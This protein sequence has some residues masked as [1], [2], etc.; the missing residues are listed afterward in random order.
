MNLSRFVR[1]YV[2]RHWRWYTAGV[3]SLIATNWASVHI[4]M[5]V[6]AAI[7]ALSRTDAHEIVVEKAIRIG[8][9]GVVVIGI[10]T[11]SRVAFFTPG[12]NLEAE[13]RRDLFAS[14]LAQQ[15]V[16]LKNYPP[17]DL[18]NRASSDTNA[19]RMLFGFGLLQLL[20]SSTAVLMAGAQMF[21]IAPSLALACTVPIAAALIAN[22]LFIRKLYV[23]IHQMQRELSALSDHILSTYQGVA[24]LQGFRA[25]PAF[26]RRFDDA[27]QA[28]QRTSQ[29]RSNL[30]TV[31]GPLLGLA[32]AINVF[33]VLYFGGH[34]IVS[35]QMT[36]G[37]L[38]AFVTLVGML[39]S[40]LRA[41]SFLVAIWKQAQ[42]SLERLGELID[43]VPDRPD[44]DAPLIPGERPPSIEFRGLSYTY[45]DATP[46]EDGSL[47]GALCDL[48]FAIPAGATVGLF[49]PAGS[50]KTTLV[51]IISRLYN[52]PE[53]T[54]FVDG[55]DIRR[56][57]LDQWRERVTL[58]PQRAFLFSETLAENILLGQPRDERL[59]RVLHDTTLDVD[60][61][62]LQ[63]GADSPVGETGVMLSGGQRQRAA[64]ARALL[65]PQALWILDDVLS[66]VDHATEQSLIKTIRSLGS[67]SEG[68]PTTLL[69]SHRISAL[70]HANFIVVLEPSPE[71]GRVTAIGTHEDLIGRPGIYHDT[72]NRQ[73]EG[74]LA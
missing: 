25:E 10:R 4:P 11:L 68:H 37:E 63:K 53:G 60:I 61:A 7:D 24:T 19:I 43:A 17:G 30:R 12:R 66:S 3:V 20:N 38:V 9:F 6:A 45:P 72:W 28:Y 2:L 8:L 50:G 64:L 74:E 51:R 16:F 5:E 62:S 40:P 35:D 48:R 52:P 14:F 65:R 58:V 33:V 54:V 21:R 27:N 49:G 55:Q 39:V 57:D 46:A 36:I 41:T 18:I 32:A 34:L 22:Q 26:I 13:V 56:L 71:G 23:L 67:G 70:Q 47:R 59:L 69:V 73:R 1:R 31:I 15:P 44:R 42:V 29:S